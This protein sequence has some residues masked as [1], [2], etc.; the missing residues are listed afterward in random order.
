MAFT[1]L[2]RIIARGEVGG[3]QALQ[4]VLAGVVGRLDFTFTLARSG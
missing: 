2:D 1:N 3:M 4:D